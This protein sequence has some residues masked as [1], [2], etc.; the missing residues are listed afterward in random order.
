MNLKQLLAGA[1][2]GA[3]VLASP[4]VMAQSRAKPKPEP[5]PVLTGNIAVVSEYMFR[6]LPQTGGAALQGGVD[7]AHDSGI[8]AGA[9]FSNTSFFT[10]GNEANLYGGY[11]MTLGG[12]RLEG[13]AI[14]YLYTEDTESGL[15]NIDYAEVFAGG[16]FGPISLKVFY[17]PEFGPDQP[18][19]DDLMYVTTSVDLTLSDTVSIVPQVGFTSG[20]GAKNFFGDEYV[21]YSLS[22]I[23]ALPNGVSVSLGV[24][25]TNL[26]VPG[27]KDRPKFVLGV[28]KNFKVW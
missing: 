26:D 28:K 15:G 11:R 9:W 5:K 25:G 1:T 4:S 17:A 21:D 27:F 8:F 14:Y 22:A 3:M 12:F 7:Y 2:L 20:D 10:T 6:G 16:G 18:T 24:V 19:K 23:K 13:G